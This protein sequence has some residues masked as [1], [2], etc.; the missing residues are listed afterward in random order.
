MTIQSALDELLQKVSAA[1]SQI[2]N[3]VLQ[4]KILEKQKM[5]AREELECTLIQAHQLQEDFER[6]CLAD[7][8]RQGHLDELKQ[9]IIINSADFKKQAQE[10]SSDF[11][12]EKAELVSTHA[13]ELGELENS[14]KGLQKELLDQNADLAQ[15]TEELERYFLLCRQQSIILADHK[16]LHERAL[17]LIINSLN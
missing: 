16:K 17:A 9:Q 7:R 6:L 1:Q 8:Q 2:D 13:N 15:V 4:V 3:L 11:E 5:E 10:L 14:V 12:K